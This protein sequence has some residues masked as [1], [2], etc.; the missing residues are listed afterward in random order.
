[1]AR[2][3]AKGVGVPSGLRGWWPTGA[4]RMVLSWKASAAAFA[5]ARWPRWMGSKVP[6]KRATRMGLG[7]MRC[8][9]G[10]AG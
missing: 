2:R 3:S 7:L 1:M 5:M 4:K 10:G 6:P 8:K 9:S